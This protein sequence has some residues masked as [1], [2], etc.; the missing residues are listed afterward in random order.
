MSSD[1]ERKPSDNYRKPPIEYQFKKGQSGNPKG[2]P[3]KSA[4]LI[5]SGSAGGIFDQLGSIALKEAM[6]PIAVREGNKITKMP[7]V[8]ALIRSMFRNAAQGDAK[9]QRQLLDMVAQKESARTAFTRE[10]LEGAARYK[11]ETGAIFARHERDGLPPPQIYP[12]PDDVII[13]LGTGEVTI[14][15][16]MSKEQ[17]GAQKVVMGDT[18]K[19]LGRYFEVKEALTQDPSNRELRREFEE[20]KEVMSFYERNSK[21]R[22][23]R[24]AFRQARKALQDDI[25]GGGG[26]TAGRKGEA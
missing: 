26:K 18:M 22:A 14:D 1:K 21:R 20:L 25:T 13:D 5:D 9:S 19:N 16:P 17:A 10:V 3:K 4:Q 11:E 23:R 8:Q 2:R 15:G 12:H 6:R 7:A 24:E